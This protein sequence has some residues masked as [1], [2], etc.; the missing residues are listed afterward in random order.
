MVVDYNW[1]NGTPTEG[2]ILI[3]TNSGFTW[4]VALGGGPF[5]SGTCSADGGKL[6]AVVSKGG[7]W[8]FQTTPAPELS[9]TLSGGN[10]LLAWTVPSMDF[11]LQQ[12]S[13]LTTN[14]WMDMTNALAACRT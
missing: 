6:V 4:T 3:S 8:I 5:Q 13:D 2:H 11:V 1:Q 14:K 7:I 9:T 10:L 12:T